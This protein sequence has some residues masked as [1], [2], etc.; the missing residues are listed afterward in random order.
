MPGGAVKT[1]MVS[2][3][4]P[5]P[6]AAARRGKPALR[7]SGALTAPDN[8]AAAPAWPSSL[9][10]G[11]MPQAGLIGDFA[12]KGLLTLLTRRFAQ[13]RHRGTQ[14]RQLTSRNNRTN[15]VAVQGGSHG[16]L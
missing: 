2:A 10:A 4:R 7:P 15:I 11:R 3:G 5:E 12:A 14:Q 16:I 13:L 6:G 8:G 1:T 9:I